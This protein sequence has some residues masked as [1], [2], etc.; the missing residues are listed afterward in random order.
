MA[1]ETW[2]RGLAPPVGDPE[3]LRD[4]VNVPHEHHIPV[5]KAQLLALV[6]ADPRVADAASARLLRLVDALVHARHHRILDELKEDHALFAPQGG[7]AARRGLDEATLAARE[8]RLLENVLR[9]MVRANFVPLGAADWARA[10]GQS[11]LM[12]LPVEVRWDLHDPRL[13]ESFFGHAD[14]PDGAELREELGVAGSL[15]VALGPPPEAQG[16]A[17]VFYRGVEVDQAEGRFLQA[18]LDLLLARTLRLLTWPVLAPLQRLFQRGSGSGNGSGAS[19]PR[20]AATGSSVFEQRW[21]RRVN[22]HNQPLLP[23]LLRRSRLQEPTLRQVV[24]LFRLRPRRAGEQVDRT[25]H[26]KTFRNVPC[27]DVDIIFPEKRIRMRSLDVA[28][29]VV[30]LA[31]AGP[32]IAQAWRG[33]S[34]AAL[35]LTVVLGLCA[36]RLVGQWLRVRRSYLARVT[37]ELYEKSLDNDLGVLQWLVDALEEQELKEVALVWGALRAAGDPLAGHD[38]DARIEHLLHDALGVEVDFE[39]GDALAKVVDRPGAGPEVLPLVVAEP[40]ADGTV[41]YRARAP[42]EALPLLEARWAALA[43]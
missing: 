11:Y 42:E 39:L 10:S 21:V 18:K 13:L 31:A 30:T 2:H 25:I 24:A 17:L 19:P 16:G 12:D 40:S 41:R 22:L 27:A 8:R 7:E 43:R 36:W 28:L 23:S 14:G 35:G 20:P 15:R 33:G 32:S 34:A 38:L 5:P 37:R 29:L 6:R 4:W 3:E 9:T 1:D 26:L